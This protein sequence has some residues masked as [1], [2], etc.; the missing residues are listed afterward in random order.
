MLDKGTDGPWIIHK[1]LTKNIIEKIGEYEVEPEC[2]QPLCE[3][4]V[5]IRFKGSRMVSGGLFKHEHIL[6]IMKQFNHT[7]QH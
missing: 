5:H 6:K 4:L 1:G 3:H 2:I 7:D